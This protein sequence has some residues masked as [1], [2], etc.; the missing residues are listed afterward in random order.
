MGH[1][2]RLVLP[3]ILSVALHAIPRLAAPLLLSASAEEGPNTDISANSPPRS[4]GQILPLDTHLATF[5]T[6]NGPINVNSSRKHVFPVQD[7][8][9]VLTISL[10]KQ[11]DRQPLTNFLALAYD[12]V[13]RQVERHGADT[14]LPLGMFEWNLGEE[15]EIFAESSLTMDRQMTWVILLDAIEGLQDF[16][17]GL[18]YYREAACQ[19]SLAGA[20][21]TFVGY[22]DLRAKPSSSR[23]HVA[24][25]LPAIPIGDRHR[26]M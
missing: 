22:I 4:N 25:S 17:I 3:L 7:T 8:N 19:V 5:S 24:R 18:R 14:V 12:L 21:R 6:S 2:V 20:M 13:T 9:V 26:N 10:G 1:V 11:L 23:I 15:L 16:L